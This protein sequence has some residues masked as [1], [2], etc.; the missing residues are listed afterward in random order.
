MTAI[1][2]V[3]LL[4]TPPPPATAG[5]FGATKSDV[6]SKVA[7]LPN[8]DSGIYALGLDFGLDAGHIAA[9]SQSGKIYIWDW[10]TKSVETVLDMPKGFGKNMSTNPIQ[11][12]SD[13]SLLAVCDAT[14]A[15]DV[16]AR[17]WNTTT[18]LKL[19]DLIEV[20]SGLCSGLV[21]TPD[22]QQLIRTADTGGT[23][24][25]NLIAYTVS[26][27]QPTWGIPIPGFTPVSLAISP[28]GEQAAVAGTIF[29][30]PPNVQDPVQR[31]QQ[32]R[33][34]LQLQFVDVRQHKIV[35]VVNANSM[36]PLAWSPDS[37]R[38]AVVGAQYAEIFDAKSGE[39]LV[40]EKIENS[41]SMNVR[42]TSNGKYLIESDL[43][44]RGKGLGVTIWDAQR[45]FLLQ[46]ISVGD[47]GS[48]AVS[49]DS[50]YLAVG[51]TGRITIWQLK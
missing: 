4:L 2:A 38:L 18:W 35:K 46:H 49:R 42:F 44:G 28:D 39:R 27:W 16:V 30:T 22:G 32:T 1:A 14:G 13:G 25:N 50:K 45:K 24:G 5:I 8:M 47:V 12:N 3:T 36:G 15:G 37:A 21:F 33:T 31:F 7:E 20:S 29:V 51:E 10:R 19:K 43:N 9:E 23:P 17:I 48:V 11:Y 6:A 34:D 26:T 40:H 41:G